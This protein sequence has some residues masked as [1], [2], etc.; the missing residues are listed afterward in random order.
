MKPTIRPTIKQQLAWDK[1]LDDDTS[2]ILFGGGAGSGKSWLICE[3]LLTNCYFYPGSKWFI[4]REELKRL[5]AS[6]YVTWTKVCSHHKIPRSDWK[7]NGQHNYIEFKNGSRIDLLDVKH[8][9]S[10]PMFERF[11]STE[12][13]GGALEEAGETHFGAFDV[14]KTRVGRHMNKEY[15]LLPKI[16]STCN[17]T[18]NWL[19]KV[20]YK[21]NKEGKL[22]EGYA[23]IQSLYHDNPHTAKEYEK[24]L[25][26]ITDKATKQ[27]LD[28]DWETSSG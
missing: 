27:R 6:T 8:A 24:Q 11:G 14:L 19:Y 22:P 28:R 23:F 21:P 3:W 4:G 13:T 9:P 18:K 12:Y 20:F 7:L 26:S 1:L 16:F 10:D 15:N 25:A 5:M 2:Y 17:P